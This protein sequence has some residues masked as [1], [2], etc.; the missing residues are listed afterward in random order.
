MSFTRLTR[1][2]SFAALAALGC[3][4]SAVADN[5]NMYLTVD[6]QFDVYFGTNLTT[7]GSVVGSGNSWST[8]YN[9]T[10]TGQLPT[11]YLY[12]ATASDH[13]AAQGFIGVFTNTTTSATVAT[14]DAAWEVFP[15]G[16]FAATNPYYPN[17][18]P[19][20][21]MPTQA[22]VDTAIAYAETN[23]L[24]VNPVGA[25]GYDNDPS[26]SIAPYGIEWG[27]TY[28]NMPKTAQWVWHDSGAGDPPNT[29]SWPRPLYGH[30]HDEFLIFR[31]VGAAPTPG[32]ASLL[33]LAG[34]ALGRRR[35]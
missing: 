8:E 22:Q 6:N 23:G 15:A 7:T 20:S 13:S 30:N 14:G 21:Q 11:D 33:C 10:A 27:I 3:A 26:T 17:P 25:S 9:F 31:V 16:A 19:A 32:T 28:P 29:Y 24:W 2:L 12:V 34:A 4:A 5:W 1:T 35:R 18:W